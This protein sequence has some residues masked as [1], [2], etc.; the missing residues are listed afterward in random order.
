MV[1]AQ[2]SGFWSFMQDPARCQEH[3]VIV[4]QLL[5]KMSL[6]SRDSFTLQVG[7][8]LTL[9]VR[10]GIWLDIRP[11]GPWVFKSDCELCGLNSLL[12]YWGQWYL[13]LGLEPVS[14]PL[15]DC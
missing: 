5:V 13:R 1:R 15:M 6:L 2:V 9:I 3:F 8:I 10:A 14:Q 4:F 12:C 7:E 11:Q